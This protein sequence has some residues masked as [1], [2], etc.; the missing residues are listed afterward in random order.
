MSSMGKRDD[1]L[2]MPDRSRKLVSPRTGTSSRLFFIIPAGL[3]ILII[4]TG[5]ASTTTKPSP[6]MKTIKTP[7]PKT[8]QMNVIRDQVV[9]YFLEIALGAEYGISDY[10]IKKWHSDIFIE[11]QGKPTPEDLKTLYQ[12]VNELNQLVEGTIQLHIVEKGGN[13]EVFFIPHS[14]FYQ[15]EPPGLV[16]YGGFFWN[17]WDGNGVIH[18]GRVVIASDNISQKLRSHLIRE[19]LT[20]VLGLMNDSMKYPD[21]I[22]YQGYSEIHTFSELD[23]AIIR[24]LYSEP[25]TVGMTYE[26]LQKFY[27]RAMPR[28]TH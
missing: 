19:E 12:V 25:I 6:V 15:Y 2:K 9:D 18:R 7:S 13:V 28:G 21:S 5:C 14:Q 8:K 16:F 17:W 23:K 22:F 10:T 4:L 11:I 3:A 20:Q 24:L 27:S 26:Q 1:I